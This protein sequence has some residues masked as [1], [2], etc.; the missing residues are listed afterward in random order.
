MLTSDWL[1]QTMLT[2]IGWCRY[3]LIREGSDNSEED[4]DS[5]RQPSDRCSG[6]GEVETTDQ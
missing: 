4:G 3:G 1:I 5:L 2:V 6:E